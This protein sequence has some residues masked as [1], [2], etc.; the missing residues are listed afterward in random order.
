ME[1]RGNK[2]IIVTRG[3][4]TSI[5]S[6]T[7][8]SRYSALVGPVGQQVNEGNGIN[9]QGVERPRGQKP[10]CCIIRALLTPGQYTSTACFTQ[11]LKK[12]QIVLCLTSRRKLL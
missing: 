1:F 3:N 12:G 9:S 8:E 6:V 2:E 7:L 5:I 10:G 11:C 4:N